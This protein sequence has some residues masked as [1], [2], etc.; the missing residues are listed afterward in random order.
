MPSIK[1]VQKKLPEGP[2]G[3]S[4]ADGYAK[5]YSIGAAPFSRGSAWRSWHKLRFTRIQPLLWVNW[6]RRR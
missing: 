5:K 1:N 6:T 3:M 2:K 4:V